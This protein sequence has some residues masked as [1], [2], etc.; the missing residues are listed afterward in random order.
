MI[1]ALQQNFFKLLIAIVLTGIV[2]FLGY[3]YLTQKPKSISFEDYTGKIDTLRDELDSFIASIDESNT[4][5]EHESVEISLGG[6]GEVLTLQNKA[7]VME[8]YLEAGEERIKA[9]SLYLTYNPDEILLREVATGKF[10]DFD[11]EAEK[12]IDEA[13]GVVKL[14]FG[15]T[16]ISGLTGK[17]LLGRFDIGAFTA[18]P[19]E[20]QVIPY[21]E[22]DTKAL[23]T[24]F[25]TTQ[26]ELFTLP[27]L[28]VT[29][30]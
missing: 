13:E 11:L 10:S 25:V 27:E 6:G 1:T 16:Q 17:I 3:S 28:E 23:F 12:T 30:R 22:S 24:S 8:L 18:E 2:I 14:G 20:I 7:G 9:V 15:T 4:P 21:M 26:G 19:S 29:V 5:V